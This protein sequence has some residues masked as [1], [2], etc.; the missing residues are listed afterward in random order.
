[1]TGVKI[2]R[3]EYCFKNISYCHYF[4]YQT[5]KWY[6]R[7]LNGIPADVFVAASDKLV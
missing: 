2:T 1:M 5:V 7:F 3:R 6:G 4:D